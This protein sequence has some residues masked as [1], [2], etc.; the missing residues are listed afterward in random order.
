MANEI[1]VTA[2]DVRPLT[3]AMIRRAIAG[4]ALAFGDAVYIS[5]YSGNLPV[6]SKCVGSALATA[7]AYGV[8]VAPQVDTEG[9]ST[10]ASGKACDI[11]VLGPVTG[12]SSMTSG[13]HIWV[14]D[15]AGRLSSVVGTKS[16]VLGVAES[17][18]V[19][20]VRPG[21]FTVST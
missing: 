6:V 3:G 7:L 20:L 1:T 10:V 18:T 9:A 19:L 8:V 15:T 11:V 2:A 4:E 16:C 14:S 12:Y 17:P 21:E 13:A 5:S